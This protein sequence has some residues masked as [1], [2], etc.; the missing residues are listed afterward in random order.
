MWCKYRAQM[1][2]DKNL[3]RLINESL[4]ENNLN[5]PFTKHN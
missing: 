1:I 5:Q 2:C 3:K 4:T